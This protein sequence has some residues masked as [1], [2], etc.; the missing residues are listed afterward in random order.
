MNAQERASISGI[1]HLTDQLK[2]P[3]RQEGYL[4]ERHGLMPDL[5][6]VWCPCACY[7]V[8][9]ST[10]DYFVTTCGED[11]CAYSWQETQRA[12]EALWQAEEALKTPNEIP[13]SHPVL[14]VSDVPDSASETQA[15]I[16]EGGPVDV[17]VP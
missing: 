5:I 6:V 8:G 11:S 14:A 10:Q 3:C 13:Q 15:M 12:L 1:A 2:R 16:S 9:S 17:P 7:W 4:A